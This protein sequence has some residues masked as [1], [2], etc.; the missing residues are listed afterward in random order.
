[1]GAPALGAT[2]DGYGS[3]SRFAGRRVHFVGIGGAGMSGLA[4]ILLDTGAQ[5]SGS[6]PF[7]S[8]ITEKLEQRGAF[9]TRRP[10]P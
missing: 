2:P 8:E 1:M 10:V 5:I 6:D 9:I 3:P 4:N 7:F